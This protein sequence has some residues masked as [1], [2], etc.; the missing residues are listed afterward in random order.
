M[1]GDNVIS[2]PEQVGVSLVRGLGP[3]VPYACPGDRPNR[4]AQE[5][6]DAACDAKR[7]LRPP[8]TSRP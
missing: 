8:G 2:L 5:H 6:L 4:F 7:Y 3:C 1:I